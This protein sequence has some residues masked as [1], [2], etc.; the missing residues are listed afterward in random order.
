M[1]LPQ[2]SKHQ[3]FEAQ[4]LKRSQINAAKYNP[5]I[6]TD[7]ASKRLR[8]K[9]KDVGL[10]TP[11]VWNKRTQ[12][13]VS[14]HQRLSQLDFLE[15]YPKKKSDYILT[16]AVV[17]LDE[18]TEK[19]MVVFF[20]NP[21]SQGEWDISKLAVLNLDDKVSFEAMGFVATDIDFLFEGD[22]RFAK[23]FEDSEGIKKDKKTLEEIKQVRKENEEKMAEADNANFYFVV[24]CE[25][26]EEKNS[27][28]KLVGSAPSEDYIS[29]DLIKQAIQR[30]GFTKTLKNAA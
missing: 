10:L 21:S 25:D 15:G 24:V 11:L 12:N 18:K 14:G 27:L 19:E 5:R 3:K 29:A 13:L 17:D 16:I 1:N 23:S 2:K 9:L 6:I 30:G 4:D 8:K 22:E 7:G 28:L 20:N 26:E